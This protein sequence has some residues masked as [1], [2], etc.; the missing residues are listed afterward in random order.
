M[1]PCKADKNWREISVFVEI[2]LSEPPHYPINA[3]LSVS[4]LV[5]TMVHVVQ[6]LMTFQKVR[7]TNDC[8]LV[9]IVHGVLIDTM[10]MHLILSSSMLI[11]GEPLVQRVDEQHY[12]FSVEPQIVVLPLVVVMNFLHENQI[13]D[14]SGV[15]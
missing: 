3:S 1:V 14:W 10:I 15:T 6:D 8:Y 11:K 12:Y 13:T 7:K 9:V 5:Q 2:G 4:K